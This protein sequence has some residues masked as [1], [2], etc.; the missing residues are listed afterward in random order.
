MQTDRGDVHRPER[1]AGV[2][3]ATLEIDGATLTLLPRRAPVGNSGP[4]RGRAL[5]VIPLVREQAG[6]PAVPTGGAAIDRVRAML[7][8][9]DAPILPA[10]LQP[11]DG[12]GVA[13]FDLAP[14]EAV[15]LGRA[16]GA[17]SVLHWDGRRAQALP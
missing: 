12:P 4:I 14:G 10:V 5:T 13:V 16:L 2:V 7:P 11:G 9:P 8:R 1:A 3:R 15:A 6:G 17:A